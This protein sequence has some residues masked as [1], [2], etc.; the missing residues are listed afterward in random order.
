MHFSAIR[1]HFSAIRGHFSAILICDSRVHDALTTLAKSVAIMRQK[2]SGIIDHNKKLLSL[3]IHLNFIFIRGCQRLVRSLLKITKISNPVKT[4]ALEL[5]SGLFKN[6]TVIFFKSF[7][8]K[9]Y[10]Y[11]F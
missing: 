8:L 4:L 2:Q 7:I 9:I 5:K 1:G 6:I 10:N 3:E 11:P